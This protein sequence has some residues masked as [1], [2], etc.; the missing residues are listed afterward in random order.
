MENCTKHM[1]IPSGKHVHIRQ[2][3]NEMKQQQQ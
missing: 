1:K 3:T 2:I